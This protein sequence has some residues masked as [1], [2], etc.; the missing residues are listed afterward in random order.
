MEPNHEIPPEPPALPTPLTPPPVAPP[1]PPAEV[2]FGVNSG[3]ITFREFRWGGSF[4]NAIIA[5]LFSRLGTKFPNSTDDPNVPS[6]R[7]YRVGFD[8]F[9]PEVAERFEQKLPELRSLGFDG[10]VFHRIVDVNNSTWIYTATAAHSSGN[11]WVRLHHRIWTTP[12]PARLHLFPM[13]LTRF[14][15][16]T[17]L[18]S[19]GGKP[20]LLAPKECETVF[21]TGASASAIW[22]GHQRQVGEM[23]ATKTVNPV[24]QGQVVI[25]A[26]E[27]HHAAVTAFHLA[28]GVFVQPSASQQMAD[29]GLRRQLGDAAFGQIRNPEVLAEVEKLQT[30][31][32]QK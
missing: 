15:D 27:Q 17:W 6:L 13:F 18:W 24:S 14:T 7:R 25:E 21:A 5:L 3:R 29:E 2:F 11:A 10:F 26:A 31:R 16:G 23:S 20:D 9:P 4:L 28:R 32:L 19:S 8:Q 30:K 22:D 1:P 12:N